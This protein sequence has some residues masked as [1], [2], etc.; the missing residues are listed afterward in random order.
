MTSTKYSSGLSYCGYFNR[1]LRA[2]S[3][4]SLVLVL[5]VSFCVRLDYFRLAKSPIP[6]LF[7]FLYPSGYRARSLRVTYISCVFPTEFFVFL[8]AFFSLVLQYIIAPSRRMKV[9]LFY[10]FFS[11]CCCPPNYTGQ[12]RHRLSSLSRFPLASDSKNKSHW[13]GKK[14]SLAFFFFFLII[15]FELETR[16]LVPRN[17]A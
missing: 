13:R 15:N 11:V 4:S 8:L 5:F 1:L 2:L 7:D 6:L 16:P 9:A 10:S 12:R 14:A 3:L 17:R